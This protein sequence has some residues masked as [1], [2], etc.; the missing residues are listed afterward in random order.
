MK[1]LF[2]ILYTVGVLYSAIFTFTY[3]GQ[4]H[5]ERIQQLYSVQEQ[6]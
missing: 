5:Q 6:L 3:L 2:V 4:A 1:T